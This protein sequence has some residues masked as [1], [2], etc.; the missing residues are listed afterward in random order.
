[1][2]K[3]SIVIEQLPYNYRLKNYPLCFY[4]K[5]FLMDASRVFGKGKKKLDS[6]NRCTTSI[7]LGN[8]CRQFYGK[9]KKRKKN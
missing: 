3:K 5:I 9:E 6:I 7:R 1:M 4:K 8:T 2:I